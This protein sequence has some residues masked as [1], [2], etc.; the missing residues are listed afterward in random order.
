MNLAIRRWAEWAE[1]NGWRVVDDKSGYTHFFDPNGNHIAVYPATPSN[2]VRRM[3]GLRVK[4][5]KAGLEIPPP[6]KKIRRALR[7]RKGD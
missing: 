7:H 3:V 5:E 2:A 1:E 4:L 6:S